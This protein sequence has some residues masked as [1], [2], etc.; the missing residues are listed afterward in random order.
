MIAFLHMEIKKHEEAIRAKEAT[1]KQLQ[2]EIY[3]E[4][5]QITEVKKLIASLADETRG[6]SAK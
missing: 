6:D 5:L 1:V 4:Q 3:T 2:Q